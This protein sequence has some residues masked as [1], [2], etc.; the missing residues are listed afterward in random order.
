MTTLKH[1]YCYLQNPTEWEEERAAA[2]DEDHVRPE[3]RRA[4]RADVPVTDK[5]KSK[6]GKGVKGKSKVP[7][8]SVP[9]IDLTDDTDE[10]A[11]EREKYIPEVILEEEEEELPKEPK[12]EPAKKSP[13][14]ERRKMKN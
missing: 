2:Q 11:E 9:T 3:R 7:K 10:E 14:E 6:G 8:T 12:K 1:H 13:K 5:G 4:R